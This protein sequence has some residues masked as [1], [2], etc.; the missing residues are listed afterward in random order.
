MKVFVCL[1]LA[2]L[3]VITGGNQMALAETITGRIMQPDGLQFNDSPN[4]W[5]EIDFHNATWQF[6]L[7]F[8]ANSDGTYE[9]NQSIPDGDY[10]LTAY[11]RGNANP[12]GSSTALNIHVTPNAVIAQDLTLTNQIVKGQ[13]FQPDGFPFTPGWVFGRNMGGSVHLRRVG[14]ITDIITD[15]PVDPDGTYRLG[16]SIPDGDYLLLVDSWGSDNLYTNSDPVTVHINSGQV[17]TQDLV[18]NYHLS[19]KILCPDGTPFNFSQDSWANICLHNANWQYSKWFN[20][21]YDGAYWVD[22]NI[23]DGDY[24]LSVYSRGKDN[25]YASSQEVSIHVENGVTIVRDLLLTNQLVKGT[26]FIPDGTPFVAGWATGQNM[27]AN[28]HIQTLDGLDVVTPSPIDIDGSYRLGGDIPGGNYQLVVYTWGSDNPFT[29]SL[30]L[31]VYIASEQVWVQD[32]YLTYNYNQAPIFNT[33][34]NQNV[35]AGQQ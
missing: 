30:S 31:P 12:Y 32:I 2:L 6:S 1:I 16:G 34:G 9:I 33:I 17:L 15:S 19:G 29:N 7:W 35:A 10:Q 18:I 8:H 22:E 25:P 26:V 24:L 5:V 13:V 14:E 27:D 4:S 3:L 23:P 21:Y 11:A 28:V 20:V